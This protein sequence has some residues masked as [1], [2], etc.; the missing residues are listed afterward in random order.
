MTDPFKIE[1]IIIE[2]V[3]ENL[4]VAGRAARWLLDRPNH[5][6]AIVAYGEGKNE[7]AFYV[8]RN[9]S[10]ISVRQNHA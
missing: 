8:K 9:K 4:V 3:P 6:D 5:K 10:S 2:C 7:V 1:R